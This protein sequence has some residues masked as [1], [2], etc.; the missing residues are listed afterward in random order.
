[1]STAVKLYN[2]MLNHPRTKRGYWGVWYFSKRYTK[3]L[4]ALLE[5][6]SEFN[7]FL[8]L[9]CGKGLYAYHLIKLKSNCEYVGCDLDRAAL[10]QA[11][12][13]KNASYILCDVHNLPI[14]ADG[15]DIVL[16]SEV[17]EHLD[18]PYDTL[19]AITDLSRRIVLVTFPMEHLGNKIHARHPEHVID[20]NPKK[21]VNQLNSKKLI[22]LRAGELSRFF[23]PC[24]VLE[25]L[26]FPKNR[27]TMLFVTLID[28]LLGK[29]LP[30]T[31]VPDQTILVVATKEH[32]H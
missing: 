27:F 2:Y 24:G 13:H 29:L 18:S 11:F 1:V 20:I 17:L 7:S 26:E 19:D 8:E 9:G 6:T 12:K 10:K 25:F 31:F 30:I 15:V 32:R 3:T 23:I 21:V 4:N 14:R 16:C 5:C 28:S 22:I